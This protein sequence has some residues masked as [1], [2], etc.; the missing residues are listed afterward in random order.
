MA[1][2]IGIDVEDL[3][4]FDQAVHRAVLSLPTCCCR[5]Q[6]IVDVPDITFRVGQD[7]N[8]DDTETISSKASS[9]SVADS[10]A[11]P[12]RIEPETI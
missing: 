10:G 8:G 2:N 1:S 6:R 5:W 4:G 7:V 12:I 3:L 11:V 9:M